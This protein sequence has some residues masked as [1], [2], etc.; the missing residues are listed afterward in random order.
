MAVCLLSA[1]G[2]TALAWAQDASR[3]G[4]TPVPAATQKLPSPPDS[5]EALYLKLS[6]VRLDASH[7]YAIRE[8]S[9]ERAAI[10]ITLNDGN[11]A[12]TE[13]VGGHVTGAFFEGDGEVLLIPPDQVERASMALFTGAAI[14]EER[15]LTAYFRFN[16]DTFA[17]LQPYLRPAENTS[18]FVGQWN[19]TARNLARGDALRLL[20]TFSQYLPVAGK[21][22]ASNSAIATAGDHFLHARLQGRHSGP[23]D[24]YFDSNAS[25]Q[26][27]A[28]RTITTCG[29]RSLPNWLEAAQKS[30]AEPVRNSANPARST[31]LHT[32]SEQK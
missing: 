25:E 1:T 15:F 4:S 19:E 5:A 18:E 2:T 6:S 27:W 24:L 23:F 30:Q 28:G 7:V 29:P 16:D 12:F 31:F 13:D 10:H 17:E 9:F 20:L 26:V 3:S 22:Q 11:I 32:R 21:G 14:L 8:A